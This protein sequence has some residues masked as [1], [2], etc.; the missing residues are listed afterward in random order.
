MVALEVAWH[1]RFS[2]RSSSRKKSM[3]VAADAR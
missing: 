1:R 3:A 2:G